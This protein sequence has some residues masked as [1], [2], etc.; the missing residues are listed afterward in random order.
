MARFHRAGRLYRLVAGLLMTVLVAAGAPAAAQDNQPPLV[1]FPILTLDQERL[2]GESR[3]AARIIDEIE[4]RASELAAE[5]RQIEAELSAEELELTERRETMPPDEFR[6]LADAFDE[7]VQRI[8]A[9][10]D[11]KERDLQTMRDEERQL[12]LRRITPILAELARERGALM[13]LDRRT[14][15]LSAETVDITED[16]ITR[17]DDV[18]LDADGNLT[19]P[20]PA[21]PVE[22]PADLLSPPDPAPTAPDAVETPGDA[23]PA[24]AD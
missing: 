10:Q 23:G 21:P 2:Y 3:A 17:I 7:K 12:F 19:E 15:L 5:N 9:E 8:R 14:V 6:P 16:A 18:L 1:G 22:R 13:I 24:D 20:L 4:T 11:G